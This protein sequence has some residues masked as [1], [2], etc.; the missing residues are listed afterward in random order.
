MVTQ[1]YNGPLMLTLGMRAE[2]GC[3]MDGDVVCFDFIGI[4]NLTF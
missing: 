1:M 2:A 4:T 3:C